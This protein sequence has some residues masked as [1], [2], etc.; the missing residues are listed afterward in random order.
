MKENRIKPQDYLE[1]SFEK[2][3]FGTVFYIEKCYYTTRNIIEKCR[4][5]ALQEN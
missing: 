3:T 5:H 2:C 4:F 1:N